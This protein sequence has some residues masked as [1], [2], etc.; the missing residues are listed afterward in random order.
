MLALRK[1]EVRQVSPDDL[2]TINK[3]EE[4]CFKDPYPAY[5]LSQL[6]HDDRDTFLVALLDDRIVGYAVV[7]RWDDHDH[8]VSIAVHPQT[9]R[10]GVGQALLTKLEEKLDQRVL[11]LE[12]RKSNDAA[13]KFYCKNGFK[14]TGLAGGY[15][16]DGEDAILMEK[17][18]QK[19]SNQPVL[20]SATEH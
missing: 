10:I 12:L 3:L 4:L 2:Q 6:A 7:D 13:L 19:T 18:L 5:F 11:K 8:L 15:Y 16:N 20:S 14:E 9:R 17:Q 1:P